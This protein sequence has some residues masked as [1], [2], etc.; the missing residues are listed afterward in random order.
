VLADVVT[1][2]QL[3]EGV[4]CDAG[5]RAACIGGAMQRDGHREAIAAAGFEI[6]TWRENSED[7]FVS[8]RADNV[9]QTYGVTST[10]RLARRR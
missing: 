4:T 6:D 1:E 2:P 7:R 9:T 5:S 8:D 10:S 3:S